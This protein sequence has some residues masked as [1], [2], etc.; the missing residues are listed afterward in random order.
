MSD[1]HIESLLQEIQPDLSLVKK[2]S[3]YQQLI[4]GI[5]YLLTNDFTKL[6]QL[7]Y[8]VDVSE[9][10]L[11]QLLHKQPRKDSAV[12]IANLLIQRQEEK[13]RTRQSFRS[14]G[15]IP[16]DEKW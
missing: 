10:K 7:L 5:N 16:E 15:D 8:R 12:L 2:E 4:E 13:I 11:K 1:D 6:V 9:Q 3:L 14:R